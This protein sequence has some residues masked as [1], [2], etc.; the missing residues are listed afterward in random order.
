[1]MIYFPTDTLYAFLLVLARV[2]G[3][4]SFLPIPGFRNTPELARIVLALGITLS[5]FPVW[6]ALPNASP[7]IG[8]LLRWAFCE[9]GFGLTVGLAISLLSEGFQIAAQVAG[10]NAGY[11]YASTIDPNSEADSSVLQVVASLTTAILFFSTGLDHDLIQL[12]AASFTKFPPGA[13]PGP[14]TVLQD[15]LVR[16]GAGMLSTGLRLAFPV[17]ALL[18]LI[19]MALALVGR[20]QQQLQLLTLAF[21]GKMAATLVLFAV[22]APVVPKI[23]AAEAGRTLTVL[24][25]SLGF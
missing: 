14:S 23:F 10:L 6:P 5:L 9:A 2:G 4:I 15:G 3:F 12:L 20:V 17:V 1:M 13:W 7:S 24:W 18:L 8:E 21:P 19:D 11:G 16:L 22:L 25:K